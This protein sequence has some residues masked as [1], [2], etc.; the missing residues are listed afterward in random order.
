MRRM[1]DPKEVGGGGN[2]T[3]ARHAYRIHIYDT[4]CYV[5]YT[6]EDIPSLKLRELTTIY[7]GDE[8]Y[9]ALQ[10]TGAFPLSGYLKNDAGDLLITK[11]ID[12]KNKLAGF[13]YTYNITKAQEETMPI[14]FRYVKVSKLC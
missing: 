4:A 9:K 11:Y 7:Y 13:A 1:L 3:Q 10:L 8:E 5:V 6:T 12:V 14:S 2:P